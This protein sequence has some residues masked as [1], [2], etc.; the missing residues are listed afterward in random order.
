MQSSLG[1]ILPVADTLKLGRVVLWNTVAQYHVGKYLWREVEDNVSFF[2]AGP[3]DGRVQ[4]FIIPGLMVAKIKF[5]PD[6]LGRR[7]LVFGGGM[8]IA[9]SHFHTYNHGL[10][11]TARKLF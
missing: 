3:H 4:N 1:A 8:Q 10:V 9:T 7:A 5:K 6:S 2:S 11:L